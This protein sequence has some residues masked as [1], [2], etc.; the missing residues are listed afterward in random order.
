MAF[1]SVKCPFF[2]REAAPRR[3]SM[4]RDRKRRKRRGFHA[5]G[6]RVAARLSSYYVCSRGMIW[7]RVEQD[8]NG[9]CSVYLFIQPGWSPPA[10]A[11]PRTPCPPASVVPCPHS[12][13]NSRPGLRS[14]EGGR[15]RAKTGHR[16]DSVAGDAARCQN[17]LFAAGE[18]TRQSPWRRH[19]GV[20]TYRL[21]KNPEALAEYAKISD[22]AIRAA[23][24]G[25]LVRGTRQRPTR[26][27]CLSA[28]L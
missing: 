22:P 21:V 17:W 28:R 26:P 23:G 24:G 27:E 1:S 5:C 15:P 13:S 18:R 20:A 19:Y 16:L 12:I 8:S 9:F 14:S 2:A 25:I 10:A 11:A 4:Q 7:W 6:A 3:P